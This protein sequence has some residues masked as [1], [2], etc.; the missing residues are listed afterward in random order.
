MK[1][2]GGKSNFRFFFVRIKKL[3]RNDND[4]CKNEL[5]FNDTWFDEN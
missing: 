4:G 3:R 1:K 2:Y 5:E